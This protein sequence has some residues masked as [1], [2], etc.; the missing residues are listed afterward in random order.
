MAWLVSETVE[1]LNGRLKACKGA[2][3]SKGLGVNVNKTKMMI[4]C[5]NVGT[6]KVALE[7]KFPCAV[8][9]KGVGSNSILCQFCR[10]L[11]DKRC[12]EVN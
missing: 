12:I 8:Y 7:G 9:R 1:G 5:E 10:C 3:E 4:S 11:V 2:L 6:G